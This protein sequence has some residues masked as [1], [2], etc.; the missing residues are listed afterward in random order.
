MNL[1]FACDTPPEQIA[2]AALEFLNLEIELNLIAWGKWSATLQHKY[3]ELKESTLDHII[4][5]SSYDD[6]H[7]EALLLCFAIMVQNGKTRP[8]AK[9]GTDH[10][11][12]YPSNH[13]GTERAQLAERALAILRLIGDSLAPLE[14][15]ARNYNRATR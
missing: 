5:A 15:L 12:D 11:I 4:E 14:R 9:S 7:R 6:A 2:A 10:T 1:S 13:S 3:D 8:A